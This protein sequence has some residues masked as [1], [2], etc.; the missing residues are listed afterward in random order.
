MSKNSKADYY[1]WLM[2][3][4]LRVSNLIRKVPT[5]TI[6]EQSKNVNMV[7]YTEENQNKVTHYKNIL[8]KI[9]TEASR[10]TRYL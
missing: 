2:E 9:E 10:I 6:E 8:S 7:M 5:L 4:H 3:E 1:Q